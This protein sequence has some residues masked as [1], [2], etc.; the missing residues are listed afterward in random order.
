[1]LM[2]PDADVPVVQLS[3]QEGLDPGPPRDRRALHCAMKVC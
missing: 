3:L 2:Y 1:M